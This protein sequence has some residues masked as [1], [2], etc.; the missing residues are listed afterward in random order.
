MLTALPPCRLRLHGANRC[1]RERITILKYSEVFG[2]ATH[3][4]I[5]DKNN[6]VW[7]WRSS[8]KKQGFFSILESSSGVFF[9]SSTALCLCQAVG[10]TILT[11]HYQI[12]HA[13]R[14]LI[15]YSLLI[16]VILSFSLPSWGKGS[17]TNELLICFCFVSYDLHHRNRESVAPPVF[18]TLT[19]NSVFWHAASHYLTLPEKRFASSGLQMFCEAYYW[20]VCLITAE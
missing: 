14:W 6:Q 17:I 2:V 10:K 16:W 4:S 9:F 12:K 20:Q 13:A 15:I 19:K 18:C 7:G 1:K 8:A 11:L 5:P 3:T